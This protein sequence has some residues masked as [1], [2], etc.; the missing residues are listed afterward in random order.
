MPVFTPKGEATYVEDVI[1]HCINTYN[2]A[3][4]EKQFVEISKKDPELVKFVKKHSKKIKISNE[5]EQGMKDLYV[6][7]KTLHSKIGTPARGGAES[8]GK[9]FPKISSWWSGKTGKNID[10]SKADILIGGKQVSVKKAKAQLMSGERKESLATLEAAFAE[11]NL[12]KNLQEG[13]IG[14]VDKFATRTKTEGV[15]TTELSKMEPSEIKSEMNQKARQVYADAQVA[16]G[17]IKT[18]MVD[19][20]KNS[21]FQ[22]AF[23]YEAM[24]GWEKFAGKTFNDPGDSVGYADSMLMVDD[25]LSKVKF[26]DVKSPSSPLVGKVARK[27]KFE[28]SMKSNSYAVAGKKA[29]YGFY[30]T[31]RLGVD[32]AFEE[33]DA[34]QES[35]EKEVNNIKTMLSEGWIREN[36]FTDMMKSAFQKL[37]A[38]LSAVFN[39]LKEF[40]GKI[41]EKVKETIK[42][43]FDSIMEFFHIDYDIKADVKL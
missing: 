32:T 3:K 41:V 5:V 6:F 29:G 42:G 39:K 33:S 27:M 11:S 16:A 38:G 10:T 2:K 25:S 31:V 21:S 36:K 12:E 28:V 26:E 23:A 35:Y 43:G 40:L 17:E 19:A 24:T 18:I 7:G 22:S 20:M 4:T 9:D 15:N 37:K 14:V 8:A 13:I 1:I 30:Q 34:L